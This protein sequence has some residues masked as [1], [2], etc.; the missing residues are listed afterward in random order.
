MDAPV[1]GI[2]SSGADVSVK[3]GAATISEKA[4]TVSA[5]TVLR[6]LTKKSTTPTSGVPAREA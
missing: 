4:T 1:T 5:T 3:M 2:V 6:L